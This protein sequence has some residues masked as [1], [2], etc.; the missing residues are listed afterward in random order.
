MVFL[1]LLGL[2]DPPRPGVKETIA[3][4]KSTK[5]HVVMIT[6]DGQATALAIASQLGLISPPPTVAAADAVGAPVNDYPMT[7]TQGSSSGLAPA[8]L[9]ALC[10]SGCSLSGTEV[11]SLTVD[12][13][14][15]V[16]SGTT[17][18]GGGGVSVFYRTTP[19]HKMSIVAAYQ[20]LGHTVAMTGDGVNDAPALKVADIGV[21]MGC[22]GTDVAKEAADMVLV[23]DN[24]ST[25]ME[26][27]QEGKCI[28]ANI[29]NFVRFQLST[30][31][32]ALSL[33]AGANL[34][35]LPSPLNAMQILWINIIMDGPPAQS[36]GVEAVE[37]EVVRRPP[38]PRSEPIITR[39]LLRRVLLAAAIIALGTLYVFMSESGGVGGNTG[40]QPH[41]RRITTMTFTTF[42]MFDMFNALSCR[43]TDRSI[44]QVG[45]SS[46]HFFLAAVGGSLAGQ[47]AVVYLPPLQ[48][49]FQTEALGLWD[50]VRIVAGTSIVLWADECVKAWNRRSKEREQGSRGGRDGTAGGEPVLGE[51]TSYLLPPPDYQ[52]GDGS[53]TTPW[54]LASISQRLVR[55]LAQAPRPI[56]ALAAWMATTLGCE[57]QG[58]AQSMLYARDL[59]EYKRSDE[60]SYGGSGTAQS[61]HSGGG[62]GER[63]RGGGDTSGE[64]GRGKE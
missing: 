14:S 51:E 36:L 15:R 26:A 23:D 33:V 32:A 9:A 55:L 42:V 34:L 7:E 2:H 50:W 18:Q 57:G 16:C 1:G 27:I 53:T 54:S 45:F 17:Q 62:R 58:G 12:E 61:L 40:G 37:P 46:N 38:R 6:G 3:S 63:E 29:R 49:V 24:F 52:V 30:S 13:L 11:D 8:T 47:L 10:D 5:V 22:S 19:A 31:I 64:S 28:F 56:R 21:A 44:F 41:G 25:L 48:A 20:R 43:S 4:L 60:I 59:N 35:G 39:L